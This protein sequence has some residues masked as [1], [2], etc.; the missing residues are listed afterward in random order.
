MKILEC[1]NWAWSTPRTGICKRW[2][3]RNH[4]NNWNLTVRAT[5]NIYSELAFPQ[6]SLK[7]A[8]L[9]KWMWDLYKWQHWRK[10]FAALLWPPAMIQRTK[11]KGEKM[12]SCW[13]LKKSRGSQSLQRILCHCL[14]GSEIQW[15]CQNFKL[16]LVQQ[17]PFVFKRLIA[18]GFFMENEPEITHWADKKMSNSLGCWNSGT[19]LVWGNVYQSLIVASFCEFEVCMCVCVCLYE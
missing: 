5:H 2:D 18:V 10:G 12:Q 8:P 4:F 9:L 1:L 15:S 17:T 6:L 11:K 16:Y 19:H 7:N 13:V 3:C 14:E